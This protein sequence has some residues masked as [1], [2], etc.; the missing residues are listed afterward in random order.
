MSAMDRLV[1]WIERTWATCRAYKQHA[2]PRTKDAPDH[3]VRSL[4][5]TFEARVVRIDKRLFR[6]ECLQSI[7]L[8]ITLGLVLLTLG[9]VILSD[10]Q[11]IHMQDKISAINP[12]QLLVRHGVW[13]AL[14]VI[15]VGLRLYDKIWGIPFPQWSR[16]EAPPTPKTPTEAE[17]DANIDSILHGDMDEVKH[18]LRTGFPKLRVAELAIQKQRV[19]LARKGDPNGSNPG[20]GR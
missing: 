16:V 1:R 2:P 6:V 15:Y 17:V 12:F 10:E 5:R 20:I 8:M 7:T 19:A 11:K 3:C 9:L 13:G 4:K 14:F 18:N